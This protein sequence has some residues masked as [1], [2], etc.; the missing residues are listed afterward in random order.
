[1]PE[2]YDRSERLVAFIGPPPDF[3]NGAILEIIE[4]NL[5]HVTVLW[6]FGDYP[7]PDEEG[8][9]AF[10]KALHTDSLP[11]GL[12]IHVLAT[13]PHPYGLFGRL[14]AT[15]KCSGCSMRLE[16]GRLVALPLQPPR[17]RQRKE[18]SNDCRRT[19]QCCGREAI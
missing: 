12:A 7:P 13:T 14:Q 3:P 2:D 19:A 4:G 10:A 5:W 6:R 15:P 8:F 18:R 16:F 17:A 1:V 11:V 9:L